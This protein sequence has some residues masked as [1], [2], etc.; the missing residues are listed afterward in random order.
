YFLLVHGVTVD[1]DFDGNLSASANPGALDVPVRLLIERRLADALG[2]VGG[3]RFEQGG[4]TGDHFDRARLGQLDF[5]V[6]ET[7]AQPVHGEIHLMALAIA[8]VAPALFD[9]LSPLVEVE[10]VFEVHV[11]AAEAD[12][13]AVDAGKIGLAAYSAAV[14]T[15]ERVIPDV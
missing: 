8:D 2:R 12:A 9:S 6:L 11:T 1:H 13:L 15:V 7:D 3:F 4:D 14:T 5:A 10:L